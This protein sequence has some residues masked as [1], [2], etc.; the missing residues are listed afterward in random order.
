MSNL[1]LIKYSNVE[2]LCYG[3]QKLITN[4]SI[5]VVPA[6]IVDKF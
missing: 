1:F 3:I 2:D 6:Y 5:A 4:S